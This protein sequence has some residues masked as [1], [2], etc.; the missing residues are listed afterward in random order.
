MPNVFK[1]LQ[2]PTSAKVGCTLVPSN[3]S[4]SLGIQVALFD[5]T[6]TTLQVNDVTPVT[7]SIGTN[8]G[9]WALSGTLT[10]TPVNGVATFNDLAITAAGNNGTLSAAAA[11]YTSLASSLFSVTD[12]ARVNPAFLTV[13]PTAGTG[14]GKAAGPYRF[15]PGRSVQGVS[16]SVT[17]T[18][19]GDAFSVIA[20]NPGQTG[21]SGLDLTFNAPGI[22]P[23]NGADAAL[24]PI[25]VPA[26]VTLN[27]ASLLGACDLYV[28]P[29]TQAGTITAVFR[30]L[31]NNGGQ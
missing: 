3:P 31:E 2:Q 20:V 30:R 28:V 19:A 4:T 7:I 14:M 17:S 12:T 13:T 27:S 10:K 22:F 11:G 16:I 23:I 1:Y 24:A 8:P 6:G 5:S 18:V 29:T 15:R 9:S 26:V 25:V 21:I